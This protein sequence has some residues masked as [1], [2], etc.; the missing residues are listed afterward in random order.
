MILISAN[1]NEKKHSLSL[2][3]KAS[4]YVKPRKLLADS[5]YSAS[6]LRETVSEAGTLPVIPYP[7]NQLKG[8]RA[9]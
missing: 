7:S 5:Q 1:E 4:A 9:F 2:F 8:V 6:N 3:S